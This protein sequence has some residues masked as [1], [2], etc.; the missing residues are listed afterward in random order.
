MEKIVE[1]VRVSHHAETTASIA[2]YLK[3]FIRKV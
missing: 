3:R 2:A 1:H